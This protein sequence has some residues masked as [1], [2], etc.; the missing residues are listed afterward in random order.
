MTDGI[1]LSCV[2]GW[3]PRPGQ[4]IE[5][6]NRVEYDESTLY[7]CPECEAYLAVEDMPKPEDEF[8]TRAEFERHIKTIHN[9]FVRKSDL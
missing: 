2:C 7:K 1:K 3:K 4:I 5:I 9:H 8:V 6:E